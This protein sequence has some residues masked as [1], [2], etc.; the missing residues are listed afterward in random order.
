[1]VRYP[2]ANAGD[3]RDTSS[4]P[5]LGK[6]PGGGHGNPLQYSC[7][8]N[9]MDGGIW[10]A[11]THGTAKSWTQ[12]S[13]FTLQR[14]MYNGITLLYSRNEH[15]IVNQLYSNEEKKKKKEAEGIST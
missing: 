4:I 15:N 11:T 12:L 10:W 9:P 7:L 6:A 8:E 3:I 14:E 5:G 2:P 13:D 1:M